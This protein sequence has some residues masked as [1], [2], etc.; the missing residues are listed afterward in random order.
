MFTLAKIIETKPKPPTI[1]IDP[2]YYWINP[3]TFT[4]AENNSTVAINYSDGKLY[5]QT[6]NSRLGTIYIR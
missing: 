4:A 6:N 5:Y 1:E 2:T 3:L